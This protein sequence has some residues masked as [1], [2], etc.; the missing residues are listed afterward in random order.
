MELIKITPDKEKARNILQMSLLI[1]ERIALEDRKRMMTLIIADY[2][3]IVKE[4]IT[5]LLLTDGYK[6]LSH[7]DLIEYMEENHPEFSAHE[8]S[9]LDDLRVL[10][11]K[12]SYEGFFADPSYLER[13]EPLF[14]SVIRKLRNIIKKKLQPA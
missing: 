12:V 13:N 4:L 3:E 6:T 10:R 7:K 2:Y 8:I 14:K 5:A 9:V 11:N 1:E